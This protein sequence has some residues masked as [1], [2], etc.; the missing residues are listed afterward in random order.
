MIKTGIF[1]K[2]YQTTNLNDVFCRMTA[3]KLCHAQLNL[4]SAG[5]P[6]LPDTIEEKQLEE[7]S[8]LARHHGITLDALS[9]T[10]NMIDP[11]EARRQKGCEQFR[12]QCEIASILQIPVITLCTG[13]RN[14]KSQWEWH[15]DNLKQSSWDVLMRSTDAIIPLSE[16]YHITLGVETEASNIINTPE[17]AR[18][19]LDMVGS[20]CLKI[21]MDGANLFLPHQ[22]PDMKQ[23]LTEAFELLGKDIVLAHAKDFSFDGTN[24]TFTAAG[25]GILDFPYYVQLLKQYGYTGGL[26]MH[27]LDETQAPK[28]R[29]FLE[30][31]LAHA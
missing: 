5:L 2:T 1:T 21:I 29:S 23:V 22:V 6:S 8:S 14:R 11:E 27:G 15:D 26:I 10:F 18:Q 19:Y 3:Q 12:L 24:I 7:I 28:S 31:V 17:R 25:E 20:P 4:S 13:S 16:T 30:E 9:G